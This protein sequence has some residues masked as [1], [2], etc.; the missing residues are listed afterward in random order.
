MGYAWVLACALA[1]AMVSPA[2]SQTVDVTRFGA[3]PNG[4][5]DD[6]AAFLAAFQKARETG[7]RRI[8]IPAGRYRLRADGNPARP[9][10]RA[11]PGKQ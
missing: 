6:T 7:A 9:D 1:V 3:V 2:G 10:M 4:G 8:V 11:K 5:K